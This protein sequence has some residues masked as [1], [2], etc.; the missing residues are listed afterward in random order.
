VLIGRVECFC[1]QKIKKRKTTKNYGQKSLLLLNPKWRHWYCKFTDDAARTNPYVFAVGGL[2]SGDA[3]ATILNL[4]AARLNPT[5]YRHFCCVG[6]SIAVLNISYGRLSKFWGMGG[7]AFV[8]WLWTALSGCTLIRVFLLAI[9]ATIFRS[10]GACVC[11][12]WF[13]KLVLFYG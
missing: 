1:H 6:P 7:G 10:K 13:I 3:A 11:H 8:V 9:L 5:G 2:E 4:N 12:A